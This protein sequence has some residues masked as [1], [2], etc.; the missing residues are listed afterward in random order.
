MMPIASS[1]TMVNLASGNICLAQFTLSYRVVGFNFIYLCCKF[2][3]GETDEKIG[4]L[5]V[6][7]IPA[8]TDDSPMV[9]DDGIVRDDLDNILYKPML[10]GHAPHAPHRSVS[11]GDGYVEQ[12]PTGPWR[13][14]NVEPLKKFEQG[15]DEIL[16][17][18]RW[19][20][21][22]TPPMAL[23]LATISNPASANG[24]PHN[25]LKDWDIYNRNSAQEAMKVLAPNLT[26]SPPKFLLDLASRRII[27]SEEYNL[28][29]NFGCEH[30]G[31]RSWLGT[32]LAKFVQLVTPYWALP[33]GGE[34]HTSPSI[35]ILN[36]LR[37]VLVSPDR[38]NSWIQSYNRKPIYGSN[39]TIRARG[40][41]WVQIT[42]LDTWIG[43]AIDHMMGGTDMREVP[44]PATR[45]DAEEC[46]RFSTELYQSTAWNLVRAKWLTYYTRR[47]AEGRDRYGDSF[48]SKK[49]QPDLEK[50]WIGMEVG[51]P[52]EWLK[53]DA[54]LTIRAHL[55]Y[56][57]LI[58]MTDT[59]VL[60][61]LAQNDPL[62][63]IS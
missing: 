56:S 19:A 7:H 12:V 4:H 11:L 1:H 23:V 25:V 51:D 57:M 10:R 59:S 60:Q 15:D 40:V 28:V 46:Y 36:E 47:L 17:D 33:S 16:W 37:S 39:A 45:E 44:V 13:E 43:P 29:N 50:R 27:H 20:D 42:L 54:A 55:L 14:F 35:P 32:N 62:L 21:P 38:M 52:H 41:L 24:F 34:R 49:P 26:N 61:D 63:F 8:R 18:G 3:L 31:L 48:L 5:P 22:A 2:V 53:I 58:S 30:G 9:I 6:G